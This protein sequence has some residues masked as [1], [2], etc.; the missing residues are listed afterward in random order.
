MCKDMHFVMAFSDTFHLSLG[1][2]ICVK[3][4][5]S[6][7]GA[8]VE[9]ARFKEQFDYV[10]MKTCFSVFSLCMQ[11]YGGSGFCWQSRHSDWLLSTA[12]RPG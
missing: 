7:N 6:R 9:P 12:G 5:S 1:R 11:R 4:V 10:F 8:I 3:L 2:S